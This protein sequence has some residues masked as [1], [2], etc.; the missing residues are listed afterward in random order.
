MTFWSAKD[1]LQR[2]LA[3]ALLPLDIS[4]VFRNDVLW[5]RRKQILYVASAMLPNN[6]ALSER[7]FQHA[8]VS[9]GVEMRLFAASRDVA[10]AT[11][12]WPR[13]ELEAK[14]SMTSGVKLSLFHRLLKVELVDLR[15]RWETLQRKLQKTGIPTPVDDLRFREEIG[16]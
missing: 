13:S 4:W 2:M 14:L 7:A 5:H 12:W 11:V 6:K 3:D 8:S 1:T 16:Q 9:F 15:S 10:F